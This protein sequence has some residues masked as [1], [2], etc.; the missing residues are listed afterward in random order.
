VFKHV[1]L[2]SP[3]LSS[4]PSLLPSLP[5]S[6]SVLALLL[7]HLVLGGHGHFPPDFDR[8]HGLWH[9]AAGELQVLREGKELGKEGGRGGGV[10]QD[11][12]DFRLIFTGDIVYGMRQLEGQVL[13]E[14][15][16]L[17][18]EGGREGGR[19]GGV[20]EWVGGR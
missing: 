7:H 16:E 3:L 5:P 10:E 12:S 14:G 4:P 13:R 19:A 1:S 15:K 6:Y 20:D 17:G 9:E 8:G 18:K 11:K 2:S